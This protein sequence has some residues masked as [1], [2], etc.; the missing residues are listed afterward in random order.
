MEDPIQKVVEEICQQISQDVSY[1]LGD[2]IESYPRDLRPGHGLHGAGGN[3]KREEGAMM[4]WEA[5]ESHV[6]NLLMEYEKIGFP[7]MLGAARL[8]T[9]IELF[10]D[11]DRSEALYEAMMSAE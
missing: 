5:A 3:Q 11:G 2:M 7:G 1:K 6:R 8:S 10:E 9:L 4:D